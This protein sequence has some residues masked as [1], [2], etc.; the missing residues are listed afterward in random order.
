MTPLSPIEVWDLWADFGL[1]ESDVFVTH[2]LFWNKE[3]RKASYGGMKHDVLMA[4]V[5]GVL[6][7]WEGVLILGN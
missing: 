4:L 7:S 3:A 1:A 5:D 2:I 6:P